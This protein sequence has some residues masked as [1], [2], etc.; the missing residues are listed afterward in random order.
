MTQTTEN[1][2]LF[3]QVQEIVDQAAAKLERRRRWQSRLEGLLPRFRT[4]SKGTFKLSDHPTLRGFGI[5]LAITTLIWALQ[6]ERALSSLQLIMQIVFL[7]LLAWIAYS[8]WRS[9]RGRI[10]LWPDRLRRGFYACL[11]I[12]IADLT[13]YSLGFLAVGGGLLLFLIVLAGCALGAWKIW[14]QAE[15]I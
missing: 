5:L 4:S 10:A 9:N 6:L 12:G 1:D 7:V 15:S 14:K 13:L 8:L 3:A 2:E 11:L